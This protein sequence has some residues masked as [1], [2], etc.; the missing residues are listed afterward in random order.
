MGG[1]V[2]RREPVGALP[3]SISD[4]RK[5][6][7]MKL[8]KDSVALVTGA[9]R[10]LGWGIARAF[11]I[12]GARVCVTDIRD[13]ELARCGRDLAA[14]GAG[15]QTFRSDVADLAECESVVRKIVNRWGRL[16]VV[17]H[18]AIYM[19]LVAFEATTP[20]EWAR[21]LAVGIGGVFNCA[22]A[23]WGEMEAEGGGHIIR[24]GSGASNR[25]YKQEIAYCTAKH[26]VEG[27]VNR[28]AL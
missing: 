5:D 11:G 7:T 2:G 25:G 26:G 16:D 12:A 14:D 9:A 6:H 23:A 18:N 10:G 21:Q 1:A 27:C 17:V 4:S 3:Q 24:I 13:D 28:R 8:H 19:P 20:E 15:F 22:H